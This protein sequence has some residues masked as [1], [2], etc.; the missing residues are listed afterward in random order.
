MLRTVG[1]VIGGLLAWVILVTLLN[2]GLRAAIPGYHVAEPSFAFTL[3]MMIGRLA[4]AALTS[5]A[6]GALVS[7]VARES[8]A[9]PLIV[10]GILLAMFLPIHIQIGARLP[11]W[12]HLAFLLTIVPLVWA[13]ARLA[14][15]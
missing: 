10:G 3:T 4:I 7:A 1:G 14:R 11:L 2:F 8:A 5:L 9:A 15:R 13:G 12:Y 6:A